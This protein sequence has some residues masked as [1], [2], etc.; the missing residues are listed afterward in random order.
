MEAWQ[1]T[2]ISSLIVAVATFLLSRR[3]YTAS[4]G[5]KDANAAKILA[6]LAADLAQQLKAHADEMP[7]WKQ[8]VSVL[9][10]NAEIAKASVKNAKVI[11]KFA[12]EIVEHIGHLS[13]FASPDEED[14]SV[15][16][17]FRAIKDLARRITETEI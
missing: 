4:V 12:V 14:N 5:E 17:R 3:M 2:L 15:A 10:A 9:Q 6:G 7:T 13:Y 1:Q 11:K 8:K 16:R